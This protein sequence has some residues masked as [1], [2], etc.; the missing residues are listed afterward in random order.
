MFLKPHCLA[1]IE[2]SASSSEIATK[3]QS[4]WEVY[5]DSLYYSLSFSIV[6]AYEIAT[7]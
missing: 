5:Y 6:L 1:G 3:L 2:L 4:N 7:H